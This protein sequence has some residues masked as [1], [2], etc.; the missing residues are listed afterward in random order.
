MLSEED[1]HTTTDPVSLIRRLCEKKGSAVLILQDDGRR[2]EVHLHC[3]RIVRA[4]CGDLYGEQ[5][6][7]GMLMWPSPRTWIAPLFERPEVNVFSDFRFLG[8]G[9]DLEA[10]PATGG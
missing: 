7:F 6:L 4:S 3:G 10:S 5:A 9:D 8:R 2:G 1:G